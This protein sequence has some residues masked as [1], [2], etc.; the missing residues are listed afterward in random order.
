MFVTEVRSVKKDK[1]GQNAK[2]KAEL[3]DAYKVIRYDVDSGRTEL[4]WVM[5]SE[6]GKPKVGLYE[7]G[8]SEYRELNRLITKIK[9]K[10]V[11]LN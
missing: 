9:E 11:K 1:N 7:V 4:D 6:Y 8:T 2:F 10:L 5:C 3:R